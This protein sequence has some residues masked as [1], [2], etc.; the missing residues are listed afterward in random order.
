MIDLDFTCTNPSGYSGLLVNYDL[1]R[2]A[3]SFIP[4][5]VALVHFIRI[6]SIPRELSGDVYLLTVNI[7]KTA[8]ILNNP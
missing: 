3:T 7:R 1:H 8:I 4:P 6:F 5:G 2:V